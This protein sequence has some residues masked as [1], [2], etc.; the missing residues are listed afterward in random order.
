MLMINAFTG[1]GEEPE[2]AANEGDEPPTQNAAT[3]PHADT[4]NLRGMYVIRRS[5]R[6]P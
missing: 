5:Y 1:R 6:D 3:S 4:T 2:A